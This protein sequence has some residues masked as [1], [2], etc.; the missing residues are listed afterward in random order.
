MWTSHTYKSCAKSTTILINGKWFTETKPHKKDN[1]RGWIV[2]SHENVIINPSEELLSSF[3]KI[4]QLVYN[5]QSVE[6]SS[7]EGEYLLFDDMG[8]FLVR[9]CYEQTNTTKT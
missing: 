2:T 6:F 4:E 1:P 8:C 5:K 3:V 9:R 7:N